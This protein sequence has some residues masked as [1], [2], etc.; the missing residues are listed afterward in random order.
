MGAEL[1]TQSEPQSFDCV[2][3]GAGIAGLY[4]LHRFRGAGLATV[5]LETADDV[6]GTWYWNRYPGA[7]CDVESLYY[8][9]SFSPELEQEWEWT[10]RYPTQPEILRYLSHVA[11]RF[12][13]RRD[14]R[15]ETRVESATWDD[16]ASRWIVRTDRGD[17]LVA[18]YVVAATGCLSVP[19]TPAVPGLETFEGETYHTGRWPHEGVTFTGKRVAVIG[20]GSTAIQ[21]IPQIA[22]TAEHVYVFQRTPNYSIPARN[23]PLDP[24]TQRDVKAR[25]REIRESMRASFAGFPH[26]RSERLVHDDPPEAREEEFERRWQDGGIPFLGSYADIILDAEANEVVAEFVRRKIRETVRD[27]ETAEALVPK[28]YPI[29]TK[30]ICVDIEYFEAFNRDNVTLVDLTT[31]QLEAVNAEGLRA[32]GEHYGV[33]VIVLATGFDAM[34]GALV[35]IDIRGREG[36]TLAERWSDGPTSYLG[37]Q[38]AGFPNLF[39]VTGPGSPSVLSNMVVSIE[40]HVDWITDCL[41]YLREHELAVIE[42]TPEAERAWVAHVNEVGSAT[43]FPRASSWYMGA[44]VP[45]KARVFMPYVGGVDVYREFCEQVAA[46][47]YDGFRLGSARD[48]RS[49]TVTSRA[50]A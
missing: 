10:E 20:T 26:P 24:E 25:Y 13:L 42:A 19:Q 30:R 12:D 33:D 21:A 15:F 1:E 28:N 27:P 6:G 41:T 49:A 37:L 34:T 8:S 14:I 9:Y 23:V 36:V 4:A 43:L 31:K 47:D 44:N 7:R 11:E 18:R 16:E 38:V 35:A 39:T 45:G 50:T 32:G 40:Q 22:K 3:I 2:V 46:N 17:E 5:V 48:R 29:G